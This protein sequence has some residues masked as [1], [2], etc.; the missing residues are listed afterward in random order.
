MTTREQLTGSENLR[1]SEILNRWLSFSPMTNQDYAISGVLYTAPVGQT[2]APEMVIL[3]GAYAMSGTFLEVQKDIH[4]FQREFDASLFL[5]DVGVENVSLIK[6]RVIDGERWIEVHLVNH[7]K[8]EFEFEI[9]DLE[10]RRGYKIEVLRS[11]SFG[12][13][14]VSREIKKDSRGRVVSDTYLKYFDI[15]VDK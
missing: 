6:D 4:L 11:S 7:P 8:L 2:F 3:S 1:E 14:D 13:E 12:Y 15:E 5:R 9:N 10:E